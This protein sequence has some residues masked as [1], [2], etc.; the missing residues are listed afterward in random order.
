MLLYKLFTTSPKGYT[1]K[2]YTCK[3]YTFTIF[4]MRLLRFLR[5]GSF[6]GALLSTLFLFACAGGGGGTSSTVRVEPGPTV[7][8]VPRI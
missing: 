6:L 7:P 2:N 3:D 1:C 5:L 4:F 8:T